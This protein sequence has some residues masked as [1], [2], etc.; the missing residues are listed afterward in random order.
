MASSSVDDQD[1]ISNL[2]D[3]IIGCILSFLS[4]KSAVSTCVLSKRWINLWKFAT[5]LNFDDM[6]HSSNKIRKK[7]FVDFVDRVLIDL[8]SAQIG[9]F[10]LSMLEK[11]NSSY[12]EKWISLVINLRVKNL[13]V[14]LQ[15]KIFASFDALFKCQSLA[16]LV[17]NGCAFRLPSIVCLSSLTIL[18]LSRINIFCDYSKKFKTLALNFPALRHYETLDCTFSHVKSVNLQ[19]PL[20]VVSIRYSRFYHTLHAEIKFY[21]MRPAKFCYSGYMSDTI[22]LEAH[23]VGFADI[24][25]YDDHENSLKKI[26]I[27][28]TKLLCI[29]PETLKLQMHSCSSQPVMFAGMSHSFA[30]IPPFGMLRHLELNSVGC[31]YLRG[32]L[33]NSPCLKTLILQEICDDGMMLSSAAIVPHCLLSTLKVLKF[34]KFGRYKHGLS[35]AKFFIEN[36]QVLERISIRC[37][38]MFQEE[39]LSFKKSS[40]QLL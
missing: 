1:L 16:E 3:H 7:C 6:D 9:S 12:I 37:D 21:T 20:E 26:G 10:S 31:E 14:Y 15:E 2:P 24:A 27:F 25:L 34:E 8:N 22:L 38:R 4:T 5:R 32:I 11:Y 13:C 35:I 40:C 36:G 18:K 33:L 28:V 19:V 29:N 39:I 17:L 23:S 30:D